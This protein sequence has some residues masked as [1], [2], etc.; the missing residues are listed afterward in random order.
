MRR[1][2]LSTG[3]AGYWFLMRVNRSNKPAGR[4]KLGASPQLASGPLGLRPGG[5]AGILEKWVL[6]YGSE[7]ILDCWVNGNN[8]LDDKIK[9][10]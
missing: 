6:T 3:A 10:G 5:N 9:N 1:N 7:R 8:R 4:A 2:G